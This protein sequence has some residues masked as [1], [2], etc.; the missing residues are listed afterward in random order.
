MGP[1]PLAPGE[2]HRGGRLLEPTR[3]RWERAAPE[4]L[5]ACNWREAAARPP[6]SSSAATRRA[7]ARRS[8]VQRY[9]KQRRREEM[10]GEWRT[11]G[12]AQ[13]T[14]GSANLPGECQ[15][16]AGGG[17]P[18]GG[19]R[20]GGRVPH[21]QLPHSASGS[22][23]CRARR[24]SAW[25]Q[26]LPQRVRVR[27]RRAR[28]PS[29]TTPAEVGKGGVCPEVR[30]S[31]YSR[32]FSAHYCARPHVH[33]PYSGNEKGN[34]RG[35]GY[36]RRNSFV[37]VRRCIDA[38]AFNE[39]LRTPRHERG[40]EVLQARRLSSSSSRS[41]RARSRSCRRRGTQ[42]VRWETQVQQAGRVHASAA[43]TDTPPGRPTRARRSRL[44]SACPCPRGGRGHGEV[45]RLRARVGQ[46]PDGQLRPG[47]AAEAALARPTGWRD[48]GRARR[49]RG[50]S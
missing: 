44:L 49:C 32:R 28:G 48:F 29:S 22:P 16:D 2:A 42:C 36:H 39:R 43:S 31:G 7:T 1:L 41:D 4:R 45:G 35:E 12:D 33:Q 34:V 19:R 14:C 11:P 47:P 26:G 15:V 17:L 40:E 3:R 46:R 13:G 18:S 20:D 9:V 30:L 37:P 8:T 38:E 50:S 25:C 24:R 23:G 10:A 27:G 5:P 6:G 21:G